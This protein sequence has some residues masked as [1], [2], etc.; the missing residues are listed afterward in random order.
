MSKTAIIDAATGQIM[1]GPEDRVELLPPEKAVNQKSTGGGLLQTVANQI[2]EE[3]EAF[4]K[5]EKDAAFRALRIGLLLLKVKAELKHGE[6][7]PWME[8]N[9]TEVRRSQ[10]FN[11]LRLARIFIEKNQLPQKRAFLICDAK[12]ETTIKAEPKAQKMV[13]MVFEFIQEKSLNELFEE[14]GIRNRKQ[15]GG[16]NHLRGFLKEQYPDHPEYLTVPLR[17]LPKDV[18]KAWDKHCAEDLTRL[19]TEIRPMAAKAKWRAIV[20]DLREQ[21]LKEKSYGFLSRAELEEVHGALLDVK[22][23]ISEALKS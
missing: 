22:K 4:G 21:G 10:A 19:H 9:V 12:T 3:F 17:E 14:Y 20:Q 23:E 15:L 1:D 8:K 7:E 2:H 18:R 6:F 11:F 13:Q 16:A 5:L